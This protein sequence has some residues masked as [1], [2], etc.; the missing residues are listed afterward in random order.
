MARVIKYT[1]KPSLPEKLRKLEDIANNMWWC[2]DPEAID[3]FFRMD[4]DLWIETG[5]NPR[6]ML[7]RISQKRLKELAE[8]GSFLLHLDRVA[9]RLEEYLQD[10]GM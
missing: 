1:V 6:L 2:W 10:R 5:Q 9:S 7:G 4:R 3:L 8:N